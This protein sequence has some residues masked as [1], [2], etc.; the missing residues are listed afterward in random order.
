MMPVMLILT[1]YLQSDNDTG[2][3]FRG[4]MIQ[5]RT[6]ADDFP[7]GYFTNYSTNY[8]PQCSNDVSVYVTIIYVY[9]TYIYRQ[10]LPTQIILIRTLQL[11]FGYRH[12]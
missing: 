12:L 2:Y 5:A 4:F 3:S 6:V 1:V 9:T 10:L 11:L 8:H 7:A